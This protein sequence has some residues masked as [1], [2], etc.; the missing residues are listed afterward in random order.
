MCW[1]EHTGYGMKIVSLFSSILVLS[2]FFYDLSLYLM[3]DGGSSFVWDML[4]FVGLRHT[5]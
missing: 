5:V 4:S 3:I 1:R 2:V